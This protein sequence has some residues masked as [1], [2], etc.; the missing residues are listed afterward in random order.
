MEAVAVLTVMEAPVGAAEEIMAIVGVLDIIADIITLETTTDIA[1]GTI[2]DIVTDIITLE[3]MAVRDFSAIIRVTIAIRFTNDRA[4]TAIAHRT[5]TT[6]IAGPLYY[7]VARFR[8]T[9]NSDKKSLL[10]VES[11]DNCYKIEKE[12]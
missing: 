12:I 3:T 6:L 11:L 5:T 9:R 1:T 2:M 4:R 10:Y 8:I 7:T